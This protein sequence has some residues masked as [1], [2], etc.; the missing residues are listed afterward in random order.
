MNNFNFSFNVTERFISNE[1]TQGEIKELI[2][3]Y[4][5][6]VDGNIL[7]LIGFI[8]AM[9]LLEPKVKEI[10]IKTE[11]INNEHLPFIMFSYKL[12]GLGLLFMVGYIIW[13]I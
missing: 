9:W 11:A 5:T 4:C 2:Q 12:I 10:V 1:I 3:S 7:W 13:L 8:M 6:Q